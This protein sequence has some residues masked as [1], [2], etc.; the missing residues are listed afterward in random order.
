MVLPLIV[1]VL[2][3]LQQNYLDM[4]E[5]FFDRLLDLG[6]EWS[7]EKEEFGEITKEIDIYVQFNLEAYKEK[8]AELLRCGF[9]VVNNIIH[10]LI[11][12]TL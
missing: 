12:V 5:I 7:I 4:Q 1:W 8:S 2:V 9:N 11:Q 10:A 3:C 6:T